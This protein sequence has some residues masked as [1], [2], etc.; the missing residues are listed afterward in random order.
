MGREGGRGKHPCVVAFHTP[1]TGDLARNPGMCP[2]WESNNIL[3]GFQ[4]GAQSTEPY[5]PGPPHPVFNIR[6]PF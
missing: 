4:A 1:P 3:F 5:Q 6:Y 2:D